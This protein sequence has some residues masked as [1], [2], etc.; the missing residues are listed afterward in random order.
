L[1]LLSGMVVWFYSTKNT[2]NIFAYTH[3][4]VVFIM[5]H[6]LKLELEFVVRATPKTT[7][8]Q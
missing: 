1:K 6:Y 4:Y 2:L 7:H 3:K 5:R 8:T